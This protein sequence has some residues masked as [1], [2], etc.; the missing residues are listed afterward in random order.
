[1]AKYTSL[2]FN[3]VSGKMG[4][5]VLDKN[6][7]AR[8]RVTP[9]DPRTAP[10]QVVRNG[11]VAAN[12]EWKA[13]SAAQRAGWSAL[14][15]QIT[16]T[17]AVG[18]MYSPTGRRLYISCFQNCLTVGQDA[19]STAPAFVPSIIAVTDY[20]VVVI[21]PGTGHVNGQVS[22]AA[23]YDSDTYAM[24]VRATA[25]YSPD[26]TRL[27]RT[28]FR[29]LTYVAVGGVIPTADALAALYA[30]RFGAPQD[31]ASL[32]FEVFLTDANGFVGAVSRANIT[33]GESAE[34][35]KSPEGEKPGLKM[36]KAA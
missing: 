36:K 32:S 8:K 15:A 19:P 11:F 6:G 7:V 17:N 2:I 16:L 30:A 4:S 13:L 9:K 35:A 24:A 1:M 23:T 12:A 29:V 22:L 18:K 31:G 33:V 5:M 34:A 26:R 14:A 3:E 25:Q 20:E 21:A 10:Q 28:A 27:G